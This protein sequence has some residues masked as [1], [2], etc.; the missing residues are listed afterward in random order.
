VKE[1]DKREKDSNPNKSNFYDTNKLK[2]FRIF[3]SKSLN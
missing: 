1:E 2:Y 3:V